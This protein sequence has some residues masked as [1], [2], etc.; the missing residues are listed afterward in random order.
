MLYLTSP[1]P[2]FTFVV[3]LF[4]QDT[5]TAAADLAAFLAREGYSLCVIGLPKTI[6]NDVYPITQSLGAWTAAE[7]GA[8][9]FANVVAE[10]SANPKMMIVHE[11][12]GRDCGWLTAATAQAYR[13]QLSRRPLLPT[14]GLTKA[15]LDVHAVYIPE[16]PVDLEREAARLKAILDANDNVN[17]FICE[18]SASAP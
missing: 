5:N 17:I 13:Q 11:V 7:E 16:V 18:R 3:L 10:S 12:M 1:S 9:F 4:A 6:D 8:R 2:L 14:I 15:R